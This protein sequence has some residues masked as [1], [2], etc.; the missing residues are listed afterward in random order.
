[1]TPPPFVTTLPNRPIPLPSIQKKENLT[2]LIKNLTPLLC[3]LCFSRT[4]LKIMY[5][6]TTYEPYEQSVY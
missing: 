4:Q 6:S 1:M 5:G 3:E 2:P